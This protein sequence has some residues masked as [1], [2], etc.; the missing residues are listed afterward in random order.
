MSTL[1][2]IAAAL[3]KKKRQEAI[4]ASWEGTATN[5]VQTPE[6]GITLEEAQK[7][8]A[9][10]IPSMMVPQQQ[11]Q[12]SN[13]QSNYQVQTT[14]TSPATQNM[15]KIKAQIKAERIALGWSQRDL[16]DKAGMSQGTITRAEKYGWISIWALLRITNA[17]GKEI[18]L[19]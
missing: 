11:M 18:A 19:Q 3:D 6:P 14:T 16:A 13:S 10:F 4:D 9:M 17:L 12:T 8:A 2:D 7:L 5:A 1:S 15:E